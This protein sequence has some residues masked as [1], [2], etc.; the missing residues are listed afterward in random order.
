MAEQGGSDYCQDNPTTDAG[1]HDAATKDSGHK[2]DGSSHDGTV[3][4]DAAVDS[5]Q[6]DAGEDSGHDSGHD[7]GH[8]SGHDSGHDAGPA[9]AVPQ[10]AFSTVTGDTNPHFLSGVGVVT[11]T[12]AL[13]FSG[14]DGPAPAGFDASVAGV[15][16][17][18]EGF[19]YVQAFD[20]V[21]GN[22]LAPA[23]PLF[24]TVPGTD[25]AENSST[26]MFLADAAIAPTGQIVLLYR[27]GK[28]SNYGGADNAPDNL[29]AAFLD[30]AASAVDGGVPRLTVTRKN[31]LLESSQVFGQP[32]AIWSQSLQAFI[33]S[34]EYAFG[35]G[36]GVKVVSYTTGGITAGVNVSQVPTTLSNNGVN[37]TYQ[38][39]GGVSTTDSLVG[40]PYYGTNNQPFLT[41]LD[42]TGTEVPSPLESP[43]FK[44]SPQSGGNTTWIAVG[45]TAQGFVYFGDQGAGPNLT[46]AP[47][48]G[49]GGLAM[50]TSDGGTLP[51]SHF[52]SSVATTEGRAISDGPGGV[53]GVGLALLYSDGVSFAYMG[54]NGA[55]LKP[56]FQV[57]TSTYGQGDTINIANFGGSFGVAQYSF[58]NHFTQMAVSICPP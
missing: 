26:A 9:C 4:T 31:V 49:D 53:G 6:H 41:L 38:E 37:E 19:V 43:N 55:I 57:L 14:Y 24:D 42:F 39:Q 30:F 32:H 23:S 47:T 17:S 46:F 58:A 20:T 54:V 16:A 13:I 2:L 18:T 29:Y 21:T 36:N 1:A 22:S 27:L 52:S 33:L 11:P 15:D 48:V 45:G 50:G 25:N 51:V 44:V 5:G 10:T 34:W 40:V 28:N 56:P 35:G 8:D 3:H 12:G 7:G